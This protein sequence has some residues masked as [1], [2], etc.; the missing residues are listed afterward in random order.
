MLTHYVDLSLPI[1]QWDTVVLSDLG[2]PSDLS[3]SSFCGYARQ[4]LNIPQALESPGCH[5]LE[6]ERNL[7]GVRK[8]R[9]GQ[10]QS[11]TKTSII[12]FFWYSENGVVITK[13]L[14]VRSYLTT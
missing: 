6:L 3:I 5:Y 10:H 13:L 7:H 11:G 1:L 14:C 2:G 9:K 8:I 4:W 12:Q